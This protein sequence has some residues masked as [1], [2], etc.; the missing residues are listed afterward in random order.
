MKKCTCNFLYTCILVNCTVL[1]LYSVAITITPLSHTSVL[2]G[3]FFFY[4]EANLWRGSE[5]IGRVRPAR[6]IAP[7]SD[8]ELLQRSIYFYPGV[9][10]TSGNWQLTQAL[11]SI[12]DFTAS[13]D[14]AANDTAVCFVFNRDWLYN[15]YDS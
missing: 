2:G 6:G 3:G 8:C 14:T 9:S 4:T 11:F 13:D 15:S 12:Y 7:V 1:P 5:E 10:L